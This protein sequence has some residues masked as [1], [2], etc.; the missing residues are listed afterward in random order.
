MSS[1]R[2][3]DSTPEGSHLPVTPRPTPDQG[4]SAASV[5]DADDVTAGPD[6]PPSL[7][8]NWDYMCWWSGNAVSL[9]GSNLSTMA[10]PLLAVFSTGSVLNA[11]IIAAAGG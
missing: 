11:G 6:R 3:L 5:R 4:Q 9:L 1:P 7:W 8:R 2:P 10:F